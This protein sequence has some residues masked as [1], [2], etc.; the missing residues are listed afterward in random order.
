MSRP[1]AGAGK[2]K[3]HLNGCQRGSGGQDEGSELA[4]FHSSDPPYFLSGSVMLLGQ[5]H[6]GPACFERRRPS[7]IWSSAAGQPNSF[8]MRVASLACATK[9]DEFGKSISH[10][11]LVFPKSFEATFETFFTSR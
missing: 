5:V 9:A 8:T 7:L 3:A 10:S 2:P 4:Q 1:G 11:H 6:D